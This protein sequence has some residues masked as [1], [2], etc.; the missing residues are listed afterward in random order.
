MLYKITKTYPFIIINYYKTYP[1]LQTFF[2]PE[3]RMNMAMTSLLNSISQKEKKRKTS[4]PIFRQ[5]MNQAYASKSES[6]CV[7]QFSNKQFPAA[8][9]SASFAV[10]CTRF[11][12]KIQQ[13]THTYTLR[14]RHRWNFFFSTRAEGLLMAKHKKKWTS[15]NA[16][17]PTGKNAA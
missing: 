7:I 6:K 3:T 2:F 1:Q 13:D 14:H 17:V 16:P 9:G 4:A 11:P 12:H 8:A 15:E 5:R 10:F